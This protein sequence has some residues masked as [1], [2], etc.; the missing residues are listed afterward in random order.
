LCCLCDTSPRPLVL[1]KRAFHRL[2]N[3]HHL[4]LRR[5]QV[6]IASGCSSISRA[7]NLRRHTPA[8]ARHVLPL[9]SGT[10]ACGIDDFDRLDDALDPLA[11]QMDLVAGPRLALGDRV[12]QAYAPDVMPLTVVELDRYVGRYLGS[13]VVAVGC[14]A[15]FDQTPRN[16]LVVV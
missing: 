3:D 12:L 16:A 1:W 5:D 15:E 11:A 2:L 9:D 6:W 10:S 8:V 13:F 14:P 7:K 4:R